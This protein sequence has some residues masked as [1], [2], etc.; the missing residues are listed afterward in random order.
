M[1]HSRPCGMATLYTRPRRSRARDRTCGLF[2]LPRL[3][4]SRVQIRELVRARRALASMLSEATSDGQR[5]RRPSTRALPPERGFW[6]RSGIPEGFCCGPRR[7]QAVPGGPGLPSVTISNSCLPTGVVARV[8]GSGPPALR[9]S[10][11]LQAG[12]P[13]AFS[14]S[15]PARLPCEALATFPTS[16]GHCAGLL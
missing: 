2:S 16:G 11:H 12:G 8:G 6:A 9:R 14:S 1:W 13:K 4:V 15:N 3:K 7:S 5:P 10:S